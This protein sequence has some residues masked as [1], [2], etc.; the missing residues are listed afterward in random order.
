[1]EVHVLVTICRLVTGTCEDFVLN[2]PSMTSC[3]VGE[4]AIVE[5]LKTHKPAA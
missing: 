1:M 2:A 3:M 4:P 5:H